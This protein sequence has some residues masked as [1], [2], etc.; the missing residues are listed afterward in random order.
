MGEPHVTA[1][2]ASSTNGYAPKDGGPGVNGDIIL[3]NGVA[4][5][6][7]D[8]GAIFVFGERDGAKGYPLV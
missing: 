8:K 3:Q 5:L 6:A 7:F 1:N 4:G 2:N